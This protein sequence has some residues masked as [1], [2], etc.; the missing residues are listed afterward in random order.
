MNK[1]VLAVL[2]AGI[3][4]TFSEFIR[5]ELI[6]KEYWVQHFQSIGLVFQT[7][8]S[9][10]V[11]WMVWSFLLAYIIFELLQKFSFKKT[12]VLAWILAFVM[13]WIPLYN[14][15]VLPLSLLL[16]AIPLSIIEVSVAGIVVK[17]VISVN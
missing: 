14:L 4:I 3:W 12:L 13:M 11:L 1:K 2:A 17:K 6:F 5:N 7:L 9:N 10:G 8:P 15:Q 16:F